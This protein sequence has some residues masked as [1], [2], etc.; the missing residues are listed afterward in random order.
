[1]RLTPSTERHFQGFIIQGLNK[2]L[3]RKAWFLL[4]RSVLT[5]YLHY[6][7][8]LACIHARLGNYGKW[9]LTEKGF[10]VVVWLVIITDILK[11][12]C[13]TGRWVDACR[14]WT[15]AWKLYFNPQ[16][17]GKDESGK[18]TRSPVLLWRIHNLRTSK[19]R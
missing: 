5:K 19:V 14:I 11:T 3:F 15:Q 17:P 2:Y 4:G 6:D 18:E 13:G 12:K 7:I 9:S 1:M 10:W 16:N 8:I